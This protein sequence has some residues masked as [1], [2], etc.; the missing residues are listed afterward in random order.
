MATLVRFHERFWN[1]LRVLRF[2]LETACRVALLGWLLLGSGYYACAAADESVDDLLNSG[3]QALA[4]EELDAARDI[5]NRAIEQLGADPRCRLL[6]AK[7]GEAR[8]DVKPALE[9]CDLLLAPA[10]LSKLKS[11]ADV[12]DLRGRIRFY[13]AD[14]MGSAA[15][16]DRAVELDPRRGPGHWQRGIS[17]YY[18]ERYDDGRQQ[19]EG[20]QTVDSADVENAVWRYLCMARAK[21]V[22]TARQELLKIGDDRR[23]PMRQIYEMFA[24]R[25]SPKGVLAAAAS[26]E[27]SAAERRSRAFYAHLYIGLYC[28][29]LGNEEQS[30]E[31]VRRAA[32]KFPIDHYMA[33]VAR[34][35]VKL[36]SKTS[37]PAP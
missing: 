25:E 14:A 28:E 21:D 1:E 37:Q 4:R 32:E 17:Y 19:F 6:R 13:A 24:G 7:V 23:V 10:N 3:E 8:R 12:Y 15:D 31:Q 22:A 27:M 29:A 18:A 34:T 35:H 30:L 11:P 9:D 2:C 16:F 20:Y 33:D 26:G 5:A 36:R